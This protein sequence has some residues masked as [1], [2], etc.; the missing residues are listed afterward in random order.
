[1]VTLVNGKFGIIYYN[2]F[3]QFSDVNVM[4]LIFFFFNKEES[5]GVT[6]FFVFVQKVEQ[7]TRDDN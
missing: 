7:N 4:L 3:Q 6:H 5:K 1:M 2:I